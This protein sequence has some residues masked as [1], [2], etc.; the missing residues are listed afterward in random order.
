MYMLDPGLIKE[1]PL[2]TASRLA[3]V[4]KWAGGGLAEEPSG[5]LSQSHTVPPAGQWE[6]KGEVWGHIGVLKYSCVYSGVF[7]LAGAVGTCVYV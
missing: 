3:H 6:D 5:W 7:C 1:V 4:P 2:L